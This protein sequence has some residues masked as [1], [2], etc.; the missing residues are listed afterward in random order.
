MIFTNKNDLAQFGDFIKIVVDLEKKILAIGCELHIDCAEEL[1]Q[2]SSISKNLWGANAYM[3]D[4]R[5]D[6]VSLINIR[7]SENNRSMEIQDPGVKDR[8]AA[9]INAQL[10]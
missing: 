10:F 4:K 1:I 5:I 3:S 7:P 6:F 2:K 8:V 9:I